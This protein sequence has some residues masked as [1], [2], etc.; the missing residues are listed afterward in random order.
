LHGE[1]GVEVVA[2]DVWSD[3]ELLDE[4]SQESDGWVE[5]GEWVSLGILDVDVVGKVL[6][7]GGKQN[8]VV[9]GVHTNVV[10]D[11]DGVLGEDLL[12]VWID[13]EVEQGKVGVSLEVEL[14]DDGGLVHDG[15]VGHGKIEGS[16]DV[17]LASED[18]SVI[19]VEVDGLAISEVHGELDS[20]DGIVSVDGWDLMEDLLHLVGK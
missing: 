10:L 20:D 3:S 14:E 2:E 11:N 13:D 9:V 7:D 18:D 4:S 19:L 1:A 8:V 6:E 12:N 16:S 5:V 17:G 15:G